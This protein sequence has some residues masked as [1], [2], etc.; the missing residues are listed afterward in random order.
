ML[1]QGMYIFSEALSEIFCVL[2][3]IYLKRIVFLEYYPPK[4][5]K[6]IKKMI[7]V[8]AVGFFVIDIIMGMNI[9]S[10][11]T[12]I[13]GYSAIVLLC[14][15][16][17]YSSAVGRK[18]AKW[19]AVIMPIVFYGYWLSFQIFVETIPKVLHMTELGNAIYSTIVYAAL[20]ILIALGYY[21][22][23]KFIQ[24]LERDIERR[25]LK[26]SEEIIIWLFAFWQLY[27]GFLMI[28]LGVNIDIFSISYC[29]TS[30]VCTI[31]VILLVL[32]SNYRT[33]Y[34]KQ[35]MDLQKSLITTMA[36]MVE[37]RDE[38]TGGHIQRTAKYVE[39]IAK[40]LR[41]QNKFTKILTDKY[42]EDMVI[43]A[44]LHDVGKIHIPDAVLNK[45]AKLDDAEFNT[46]KTHA[47]AGAVI[48]NKVEA[49]VGELQYLVLAKQMAEF[50]HERIDG[51]GYPHGLTGS[52]IPLCAKIL[53]VADV[54]D[55]LI[56]KRCYKP[57]MPIEQAFAI[58][59]EETGTHFDV[60]VANAFLDSKDE[61]ER[62]LSECME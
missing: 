26:P 37:N 48:I 60:D 19:L 18:R 24:N 33:Y 5:M 6:I 16:I 10:I 57:A 40:K 31:A 58:I 49:S 36:D 29:M 2:L 11:C 17:I 46:M 32:D 41:S 20:L 61:I 50:H 12:D 38:N 22:K 8:C 43:A 54:F 14:I 51:K 35:N 25:R 59:R 28:W 55:A 27:N 45:P 9:S 23:P 39:I 21:K 44:P 3:S 1:S 15:P 52:E 7:L 13:C 47:Q 4:Q 34:H 62:Y 42:I 53:A 30:F 56:S